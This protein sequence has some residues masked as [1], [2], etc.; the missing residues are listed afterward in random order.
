MFDIVQDAICMPISSRFTYRHSC[1]FS[2]LDFS[3]LRNIRHRAKI[4]GEECEKCI[5]RR[6][7]ARA[8]KCDTSVEALILVYN[9]FAGGR[10][11][12]AKRE[13]GGGKRRARKIRPANEWQVGVLKL[14]QVA[15]TGIALKV[16]RGTLALPFSPF[17]LFLGPPSSKF[18]LTNQRKSFYASRLMHCR[19]G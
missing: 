14:F 5:P 16:R 1:V 7:R 8:R 15:Y 4:L 17:S 12:R 9:D 2:F 19:S 11:P 6:T 10:H 3:T 13:L 18:R